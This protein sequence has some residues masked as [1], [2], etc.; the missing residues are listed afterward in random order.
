[1]SEKIVKKSS[2]GSRMELGPSA[3]FFGKLNFHKN[4]CHAAES[5]KKLLIR[6]MSKNDQG[7]KKL[8][9]YK[10]TDTPISW[11]KE[12]PNTGNEEAIESPEL[13]ETLSKKITDIKSF[14]TS[15]EF[16]KNAFASFIMIL[17]EP[18]NDE[19]L[20]VEIR[21]NQLAFEQNTPIY[22]G[23]WYCW[24]TKDDEN[25]KNEIDP[26]KHKDIQDFIEALKKSIII[27]SIKVVEFCVYNCTLNL[28]RLL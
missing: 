14:V 2:D 25:L 7:I 18:E 23:N 1:M 3:S 4:Q 5:H 6:N 26:N 24:E 19:I 17:C 15:T 16:W 9:I 28:V 12:I 10:K 21:T 11:Y 20:G 22:S 13:T 27:D 8:Y